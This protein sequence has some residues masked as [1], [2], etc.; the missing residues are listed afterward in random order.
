[1]GSG[2]FSK[3]KL[4]TDDKDNKFAIKIMKRQNDKNGKELNKLFMNEVNI[5]KQ[6]V[7]QNIIK[8]HEYSEK[9]VAHKPDGSTINVNYMAIGYADFGEIFDI[10][11]ETGEF[12]DKL[13]RSYFHQLI[14]GVEYMH[15]KGFAHRDLKPENLL[16]GKNFDLKIADFGFTTK[17]KV[18]KARTGTYGYMAPELYAQQ[19]YNTQ[20]VD[21]WACGVILFVLVT[22]HS[23]FHVA[24]PSDRYYRYIHSQDWKSFWSIYDTSDY[25]EAFK[26]LFSRMVSFDPKDRLTLEQIKEHPWFRGPVYTTKQIS[27]IMSKR[28]SKMNK[29][30]RNDYAKRVV[31]NFY[32]VEDGDIL[33]DTAVKI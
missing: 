7:H 30:K 14:S 15:Q 21:I 5:Y 28:V 8:L 31:T 25:S 19:E 24:D 23:P 11:A 10:I 27:D 33:V 26:D 13:A 4:G 22:Q 3:V 29:F 32:K 12:E 16:I 6:L 1:L 9:A 18:S 2:S 17:D 20:E